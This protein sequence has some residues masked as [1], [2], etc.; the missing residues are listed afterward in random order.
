[1]VTPGRL[2][3]VPNVT[4][5]ELAYAHASQA[6]MQMHFG[7]VFEIRDLGSHT[8]TTVTTLALLLAGTVDVRPDPK[9][10]NF[11]EV[12][13]NS[14]V[15]Y[16]HVSPV[17]GIIYLLAVW[18]NPVIQSNAGLKPALPRVPPPTMRFEPVPCRLS[19]SCGM[20]EA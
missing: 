11:Y 6:P 5:N 14:Q 13:D 19:P 16:I 2:P 1:V 15:Y 17:T 10:K 12:V 20:G 8:A 7:E 18:Q 9:R 3:E 4:K